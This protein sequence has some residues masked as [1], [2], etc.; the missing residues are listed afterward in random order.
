VEGS[1]RSSNLLSWHLP[2]GTT[3][4]HKNS[5]RIVAS[6]SRNLNPGPPEYKAG[7]VESSEYFGM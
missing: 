4:N 3:E 1:G 6:P 5:V 2:G 7:V